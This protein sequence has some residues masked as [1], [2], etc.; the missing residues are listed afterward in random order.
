MIFTC[1]SKANCANCHG[2]IKQRVLSDRPNTDNRVGCRQRNITLNINSC[3]TKNGK[4]KLS[5][6]GGVHCTLVAF[7]GAWYGML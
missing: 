2:N 6:N 5:L 1:V 4:A 3:K 7:I